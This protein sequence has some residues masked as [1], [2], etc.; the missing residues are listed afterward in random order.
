VYVPTAACIFINQRHASWILAVTCQVYHFQKFLCVHFWQML[1]RRS[2][3][4]LAFFTKFLVQSSGA[5]LRER[6]LH[7]LSEPRGCCDLHQTCT[8]SCSRTIFSSHC[9]QRASFHAF[10]SLCT[11]ISNVARLRS[12]TAQTASRDACAG[13]LPAGR[14]PHD[15]LSLDVYTRSSLHLRG[16]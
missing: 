15:V 2:I 14:T 7:Y 6:A 8:E 12:E 16:G 5:V 4:A 3:H 10:F 9:A 1:S 13:G 11:R